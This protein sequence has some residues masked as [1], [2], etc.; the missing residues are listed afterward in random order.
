[1]RLQGRWEEHPPAPAALQSTQPFAID[2][3]AFDQ[4]LQWIFVPK[5]Q[6]LVTQQLPLPGQCAVQAMAEETYGDDNP[7]T[8]GIILLIAQ[9]DTLL[10]RQ[11]RNLN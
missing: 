10:T 9:I 4:W 8:Q 3:L 11:G 6:E 7:G 2:T 1:M 5:L